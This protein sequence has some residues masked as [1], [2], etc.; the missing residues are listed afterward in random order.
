MIK[1]SVLVASCWLAFL[2]AAFCLSSGAQAQVLGNQPDPGRNS[3]VSCTCSNQG[4]VCANA[5]NCCGSGSLICN[6][7]G[8][9][10]QPP[11]NNGAACGNK[12]DC[13]SGVCIDNIC[14]PASCNCGASCYSSSTNMSITVVC[15]ASYV[16]VDSSVIQAS[17][18]QQLDCPGSCLT[19]PCFS[20]SCS[21]YC[22]ACNPDDPIC[23]D[24]N[25]ENDPDSSSCQDNE[26]CDDTDNN[27]CDQWS[28]LWGTVDCDDNGGNDGGGGC[29]ECNAIPVRNGV[30]V[31]DADPNL[32]PSR[33]VQR[34]PDQSHPM[35]YAVPLPSSR[36]SSASATVK[37][38]TLQQ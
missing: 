32:L 29:E 26:T 11:A 27:P 1:Q 10:C 16:C 33:A 17:G 37:A 19:N 4:D 8:N 30:P 35:S 15:S 5:A 9:T 12:N 7:S 28:C 24:D 20:T 34:S 22:T 14:Q 2:A 6:S 36:R 3:A 13:A 23:V 38:G 31:P 18:G 21:N 25:C